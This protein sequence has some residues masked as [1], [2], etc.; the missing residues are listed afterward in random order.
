MTSRDV[1]LLNSLVDY[2]LDVKPYHTKIKQFLSELFFEDSF[3]ANVTDSLSWNVYHQNQWTRD[4]VGG[5]Y[6]QK[7]CEGI[8]ADLTFRIPAA[9]WPRRSIDDDIGQ[10]PPGDD[11]AEWDGITSSESH[12]LGSNHVPGNTSKYAVPF[13]QGSRVYVDGVLQVY[14][15]DYVVDTTRGFILFA[16]PPGALQQIDVQLF[17]VDRLF[18]AF[19]YPFDV[20]VNRD[21]DMY[22]YDLLPYDSDE[23]YPG[24][25]D[26]DY[27]QVAIDHSQ[28]T[29]HQPVMFHNAVQYRVPK[30]ELRMLGVTGSTVTGD[31]WRIKA[32][33]PW[34]FIVQK[35]G[36]G[37]TWYAKF[38]EIFDNGQIS[39]II[40]KVWAN[41]YLVPDTST[42]D[43]SVESL[44]DTDFKVDL[45][46]TT[47]H[48]VVTDPAPPLHRPMEFILKD[49][50]VLGGYDL[51]PYGTELYDEPNPSFTPGFSLGKVK[52]ITQNLIP[53][54][55]DYYAFV[56]SEI[57]L[58]G[59]YV[60][61]RIEQNGQLNPWINS[62]V[63]DDMYMRVTWPN[64]ADVS[65]ID[66][67]DEYPYDDHGYDETVVYYPPGTTRLIHNVNLPT[68]LEYEEPQEVNELVIYHGRD[69]L[70]TSVVVEHLG[71]PITMTTVVLSEYFE[72]TML[73]PD[74]IGIDLQRIVIN[75][76]TPQ[77]IKVTLTF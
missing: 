29:G 54:A 48:G 7:L 25:L 28:L 76:A 59:T 26:S 47:E 33:G 66:L 15:T 3:N 21:Y 18:I 19:N 12:F 5:Y 30:A 17:K 13:H 73:L 74:F 67:Y 49:I 69:A 61:L 37:Q 46:L 11:P 10:T 42:Y 58:R 41:Y 77:T 45:T 4:D 55:L 27:F 2:V 32:V 64:G 44:D 16:T 63:Q 71:S 31:V 1:T 22:A 62:N 34:T 39:F 6:L 43:V 20:N 52:K 65:L 24:Q 72:G 50:T 8:Q 68:Q 75:L 53:G 57:P 38:K 56:L 40:D 14:G 70:P 35:N 60:E 23:D 36:A 51:D 9:V